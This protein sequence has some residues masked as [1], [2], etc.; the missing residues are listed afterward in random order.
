M[1]IS[2]GRKE[3]IKSFMQEARKKH[4]GTRRGF[5][6]EHY[7]AIGLV[8]T[9]VAF[10]AFITELLFQAKIY[11]RRN[12]FYEDY[13]ESFKVKLSGYNEEITALKTELDERALE[14]MSPIFTDSPQ[15]WQ[16]PIKINEL[17]NFKEIIEVIYRVRSNLVH[18][19]KSL[20]TTRNK[21]LI[22]NS[23]HLLFKIMDNIF[24]EEEIY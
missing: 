14:N 18:G 8:E 1:T 19:S 16:L 4:V 22:G 3:I 10:E 11:Q 13:E 6:N 15:P 7:E 23:F 17:D 24:K 2:D 12:K 20:T 5:N 21:I 9:C